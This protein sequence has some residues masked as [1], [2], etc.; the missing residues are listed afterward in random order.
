MGGWD[1]YL[2]KNDVWRS[3]DY[4]A[5]WTQVNASAGWSGRYRH[6]SMAMPDGSIVLMGG[7]D[8]GY[9][10]DVWR[11]TDNGSTWTQ[12]NPSAEWSARNLHTSMAMPDGSIILMGGWDGGYKN[13]VWRSTDNGS[14]WTQVNPSVGWSARYSHSSVAMPDGSIVLMGGVDGISPYKN[15]VWRSSDYGATWTQVNAGTEWGARQ[16]HSN[17]ALPDGS[18]VLMGGMDS[19]SW[20]ND[21]WRFMPAGSS[22]QNPSHTY[23]VPGTYSVALQTYNAGGYNSTQKAGYINVSAEVPT[24]TPISFGETVNGTINSQGQTNNYTFN[25]NAGDTIYSRMSSSWSGGPQIRL[26][27]PNGTQISVS[28]QSLGSF[29]TDMTLQLPLTGTYTLLAGD[30]F[31]DATGTYGLFLQRTNDAGNTEPIAFG[32]TKAGSITRSAEMKNYTFS[33][34]AGDTI[35]S[36]MSSSWSGGPQIRLYAPN[37]TQISVSTQSLGSFATDM[38]LQLPLTGTYTLLAGDNFGDATG[39]YGLFLQR[40]NDAGNTEPIAFGETKAGSITR[41]AEMMNYTFD[42]NAGDTI[43]SR[44]SSSWSGGP[45]IRLY[46]PNGTQISVSTQSLGSFA[47]DMTLQLPLTGT[48]TLLAGDNFGDATGTYGLFLQR[49]ND[50]GNTEPIAFGETKAGSIT[51]SAEMMNYTFDA[52][53]GDTIYSRM[54]SSWSGGP[55]IRLYAPNGTQISVSTQSLGSF[56]TDM[57]LQLP[58]TGTYT[59]LAGDNFGDATGTYNLLVTLVDSWDGTSCTVITTPVPIRCQ[60]DIQGTPGITCIDIRSS[61]VMF[62]GNG[63]TLNGTPGQSRCGCIRISSRNTA[64]LR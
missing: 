49:T 47:T 57:T 46:A 43:F 44:M 6:T 29:A 27:A 18:I 8:G 28:T 39:T 37:G 64:M 36:R 14:T 20:L 26:Y 19:S 1:G 52:N 54:S 13:D 30:N 38:T 15:D 5:T 10:N 40:T 12:V 31:G 45:Q 17:V 51:R 62:E 34:N 58:L 23:T 63:H 35:Y 7:W 61:D 21:V 56:A 9:K 4:G 33:A 25:A 55:Q 32:E 16:Y 2:L 41:S 59:L 50:A 24:A 3:S 22:L 11:S 48:Y 60:G 53:A 42:A